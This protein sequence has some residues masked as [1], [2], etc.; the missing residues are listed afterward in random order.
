M[1]APAHLPL[2]DYPQPLPIKPPVNLFRGPWLPGLMPPE[3]ES[4]FQ[5]P[6]ALAPGSETREEMAQRMARSGVYH[7]VFRFPL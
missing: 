7:S 5:Y 6:P 4:H 1:F 3:T 2:A